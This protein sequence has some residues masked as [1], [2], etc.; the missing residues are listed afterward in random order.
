MLVR[1]GINVE[2]QC[3]FNKQKIQKKNGDFKKS[4]HESSLYQRQT[5]VNIW[6]TVCE[7]AGILLFRASF[8]YFWKYYNLAT[9]PLN[10][11]KF[12]I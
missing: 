12:Q 10:I 5:S 2:N 6:I 1:N 7:I 8:N 11:N 3:S 4:F 9:F